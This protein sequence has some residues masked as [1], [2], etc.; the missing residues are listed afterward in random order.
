LETRGVRTTAQF[1]SKIFYPKESGKPH[2]WTSDN[3][4]NY[5]FSDDG[6][7]FKADGCS[8]ELSKDG[9]TYHIKSS[10]S[11]QAV[12]DL[13]FTQTA[14]GFAVGKNGVST[15][16]TDPKAP[17]G[18]M[19]HVFWPRCQ[20]EGSIVTKEGPVDFKGRGMVAHALQ[21][22]KPHFAGQ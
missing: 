16:G 7:D 1:S 3:V 4:S 18:K 5:S 13:K 6:L 17:W 10:N 21:G 19:K 11:K 14:P 20:V 8:M 9:K 12:V 15:Y 22:M 2:L